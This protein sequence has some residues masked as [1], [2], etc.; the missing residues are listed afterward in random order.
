MLSHD[1]QVEPLIQVFE[2]YMLRD[3]VLADMREP[4]VVATRAMLNAGLT[5]QEI[6]G[7]LDGAVQVAATGTAGGPSNS[8]AVALR[9]HIGAWL[10]D[11]CFDPAAGHPDQAD[12][13]GSLHED[14]FAEN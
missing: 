5:P 10:M 1:P 11:E 13:L 7:V 6:L 8:Q 9:E 4:T 2:L 14:R 12:R 3:A